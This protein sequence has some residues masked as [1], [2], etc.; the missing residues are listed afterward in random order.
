MEYNIFQEINTDFL[1]EEESHYLILFS[2][3]KEKLLYTI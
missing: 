1:F 2:K 3:E